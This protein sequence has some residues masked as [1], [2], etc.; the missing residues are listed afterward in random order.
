MVDVVGFFNTG[1]LWSIRI[2]LVSAITY[3]LYKAHRAVRVRPRLSSEGKPK[4]SPNSR[5]PLH[6]LG[7]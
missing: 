3:Q 2:I 4:R 1:V 6:F 5:G 7:V